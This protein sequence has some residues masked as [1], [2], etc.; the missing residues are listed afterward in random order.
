MVVCRELR[1]GQRLYLKVENDDHAHAIGLMTWEEMA[2][3]LSD[4]CGGPE[5]DHIRCGDF[6]VCSLC[7]LAKDDAT[8]NPLY[9]T[10]EGWQRI[11]Q[12]FGALQELQDNFTWM[13]PD[14]QKSMQKLFDLVATTYFTKDDKA[15][16][17]NWGSS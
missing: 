9:P 15:T 8:F 17:K 16:L 14:P 2:N 6:K 12:G 11:P 13:T 7:K 10:S 4:T 3:M 1:S 5:G